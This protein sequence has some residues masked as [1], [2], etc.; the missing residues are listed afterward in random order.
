MSAVPIRYPYTSI[1]R[2]NELAKRISRKQIVIVKNLAPIE[3]D[4]VKLQSYRLAQPHTYLPLSTSLQPL[5]KLS[6]R[7]PISLNAAEPPLL[8]GVR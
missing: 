3:P 4:L 7:L 8:G 6:Q 1:D 2:R 5:Y